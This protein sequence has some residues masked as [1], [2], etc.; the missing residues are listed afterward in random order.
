MSRKD[1]SF[2]EKRLV[3]FQIELVE[4]D[5]VRRVKQTS[6]H[7]IRL[8]TH[9][10]KPQSTLQQGCFA[11]R[12]HH[13]HTNLK[14]NHVGWFGSDHRR[15]R[16]NEYDQTGHRQGTPN[17]TQ[18]THPCFLLTSPF[19]SLCLLLPCVSFF[20]VSSCPCEEGRWSLSRGSTAGHA[21]GQWTKD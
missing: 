11:M 10:K 21:C 7:A 8:H 4:H 20:L 1:N 6:I 19:S 12:Y 5:V 2:L 14:P 16:P 17:V 3:V 13:G 9:I 15:P 18:A